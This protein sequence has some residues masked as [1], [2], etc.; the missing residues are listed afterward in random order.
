MAE[1]PRV[2]QRE[3]GHRA[4]GKRSSGAFS[5][6]WGR[7]ARRTGNRNG[8]WRVPKPSPGAS[9]EAGEGGPA[10]RPG[11]KRSVPLRYRRFARFPQRERPL[12][13]FPEQCKHFP[14][15][16][17]SPEPAASLPGEGFWMP[18]LPATNHQL[19]DHRT[20]K[21]L[22]MALRTFFNSPARLTSASPGRR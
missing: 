12:P 10:V 21:V 11:R 5:A 17:P 4:P 15:N 18:H 8:G 9:A 14:G 7:Q 2:D 16:P 13:S 3:Q 6:R 22:N 20:N 19:P 1:S